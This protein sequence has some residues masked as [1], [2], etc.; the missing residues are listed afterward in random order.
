MDTYF[1]NSEEMCP[2]AMLYTGGMVHVCHLPYSQ[3]A[4]AS[5]PGWEKQ[6]TGSSPSLSSLKIAMVLL[7]LACDMAW[8]ATP[9]LLG[10]IS[11]TLKERCRHLALIT[12]LPWK[13]PC[14]WLCPNLRAGFARGSLLFLLDALPWA[15]SFIC[16]AASILSLCAWGVVLHSGLCLKLGLCLQQL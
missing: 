16:S 12:Y 13:P 10:V 9:I 15:A 3:Y 5:S 11:A 14:V 7:D 8:R 1:P 6:R 4:F 2:A